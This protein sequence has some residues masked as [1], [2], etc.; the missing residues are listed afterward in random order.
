MQVCL[1]TPGWFEVMCCVSQN[2]YKTR[3]RGFQA[4]CMLPRSVPIATR[5]ASCPWWITPGADRTQFGHLLIHIAGALSWSALP[6]PSSPSPCL[7][8]H[9]ID[10]RNFHFPSCL[11]SFCPLRPLLSNTFTAFQCQGASVMFNLTSA[12]GYDG[13]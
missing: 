7:R 1:S 9:G 13:P 4:V 8:C 11:I 2:S 6:A 10:A 3:P 12:F 5:W